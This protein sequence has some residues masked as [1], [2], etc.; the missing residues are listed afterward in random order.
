MLGFS[1]SAVQFCEF[2]QMLNIMYQQVQSSNTE[3][4]CQ[5]KK[6][7]VLHLI[8]SLPILEVLP[9]TGLFTII[10]DLLFPECHIFTIIYHVAPSDWLLSLSNVHLRF[11]HVFSWL[12]SYFLFIAD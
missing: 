1:L 4:L 8:N 11:I 10:I 3:Q 9:I 12:D 7:S 5:T 2:W 6:F